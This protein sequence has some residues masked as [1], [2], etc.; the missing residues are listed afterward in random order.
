[1]NSNQELNL[2]LK[3]A[4]SLWLRIQREAFEKLSA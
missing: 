1:L 2:L 4:D 3:D